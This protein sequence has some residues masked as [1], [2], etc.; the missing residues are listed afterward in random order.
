MAGKMAIKYAVARVGG[1]GH[2]N[3]EN[4]PVFRGMAGS[5]IRDGSLT[6]ENYDQYRH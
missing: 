2:N 6:M 5:E 3:I 1:G 4:N